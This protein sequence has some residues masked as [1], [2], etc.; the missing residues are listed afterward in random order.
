MS[1]FGFV[2]L[3]GSTLFGHEAGV[4]GQTEGSSAPAVVRTTGLG[5]VGPS[6]PVPP[7]LQGLLLGATQGAEVGGANLPLLVAYRP[8]GTSHKAEG[9]H[10]L[11][12]HCLLAVGLSPLPGLGTNSK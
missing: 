3:P 9:L 1:E 8:Q 11:F 7:R 4:A 6:R 2:P 10:V 5:S 12:S